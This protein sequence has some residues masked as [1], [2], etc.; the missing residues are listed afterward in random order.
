M[1]IL[2]SI[3]GNTKKAKDISDDH[4]VTKQIMHKVKLLFTMNE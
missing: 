4:R 3:L 1:G 2:H